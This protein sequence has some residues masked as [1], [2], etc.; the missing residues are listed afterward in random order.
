MLP[1]GSI[2]KE[3][4]RQAPRTE[5]RGLG[6]C[7]ETDGDKENQGSGG[8]CGRL[9]RQRVLRFGEIAGEER[10]KIRNRLLHGRSLG[11]A[12]ERGFSGA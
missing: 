6:Y 5:E 11:S 4:A 1:I 3:P 7:C 8:E 9:H 2:T 10:F 12:G